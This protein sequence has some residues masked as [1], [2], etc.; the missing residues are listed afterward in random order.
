MKNNIKIPV[1]LQIRVDD[2]AWQK[3]QDERCLRKPSRS[4]LPR[5][6]HPLDYIILN[7]LGK[8]LDMHIGCSLVLG[9]WDKDNILRGVPHVTFNEKGWDRASELDM[10]YCEKCF[11]ALDGGEYLDYTLHGLMHGYYVDDKLL[12]EL[13]YY[14][15]VYDKEKGCYLKDVYGKLPYDEFRRHIELFL[16]IYNSWGFKKEILSFASPCGAIGTP[17]SNADY[18]DIIKEYGMIYWN[19]GFYEFEHDNMDVVNGVICTQAVEFLP[20]EAYDIDPRYMPDIMTGNEERPKTDYC[21]HWTNYIRFNPENNLE[22]LPLWIDYF[23]RQSEIFGA[24][25]S[26]NTGFAASQAVYNRFADMKFED[27]KCIIDLAEVDKKGAIGLKN[28]FYVSF[29][30]GTVPSSFDGGVGEVYETKK[31]FTTYKITR[32]N[33]DRVVISF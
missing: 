11:E 7:E 25:L 2:V 17:Q 29:K 9:E 21:S 16:Q 4:G 18:A 26:R 20:W 1:A 12:V 23:N 24:M 6:H 30:N 28:E 10:D 8:A 31:A 22:R 14:P 3:G 5:M 19:N 33:S 27:G 15:N 32:D 13:Q